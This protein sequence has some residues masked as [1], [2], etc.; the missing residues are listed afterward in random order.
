MNVSRCLS[1][2][3]ALVVAALGAGCSSPVAKTDPPLAGARIGGPFTL[4]DQN[5]HRVSDRD[6]GGKYR[7]IYFGY[8]YCPDVCPVD[9]QNIAQGLKTLEKSDSAL[10]AKVVPIFISVDP[11]RDTPPVLK[12]FVGAFHP[13]MVGLTGTPDEI[14]QVA[15]EFAII[16]RPQPKNA[17][18]G[19]AVDHSRVAYLFGK[20]GEPLAILR[21]DGTP[22]QIAADIRQWAQ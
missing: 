11:A 3:V 20:Q 22:D 4:I 8:T 18:G 21:Q 12:Q 10:A 16:Y 7:I 2:T 5:G 9:V 13:R 15:R 19:Y 17:G 14:A 6:F 1:L